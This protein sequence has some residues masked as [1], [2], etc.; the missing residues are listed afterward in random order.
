MKELS[1]REMRSALTHLED[2]LEEEGEVLITRR[3]RAVARIMPLVPRRQVP[4]HRRM[5]EEMGRMEVGSEVLVR[6][7][8]DGR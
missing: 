7:D 4:S 8:R 6:E 5:R 2:L 3:G 1:V